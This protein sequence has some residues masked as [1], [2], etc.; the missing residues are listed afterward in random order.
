MINSL[1]KYISAIII[2]NRLP[3]S[4]LLFS[5]F[6]SNDLLSAEYPSII[7]LSD[8][9]EFTGFK[10]DGEGIRD[11]SGFS[12]NTAGDM[13]GDGIDDLVI[14]AIGADFVENADGKTYVIF[15][16][17]DG[18]IQD[19]D[20]SD[21]NGSDGFTITGESEN[22]ETGHSVSTAGDIN[23]DGIGDLIIGAPMAD[24]NYSNSRG[25]SYVVFGRNV[26]KSGS[27]P[28]LVRLD[29]LD[30]S[31]GFELG[32][33]DSFIGSG[34]I[35]NSAGDVN[36]DGIGDLV[37]G[38]RI[39][40]LDSPC[41]L[42]VSSVVFGR[43][44]GT[45]GNFPFFFDLNDLD[46]S[47][48]FH[49]VAESAGDFAGRSVSGAG[50]INNDGFDDLIVG[51]YAGNPN[52]SFSGRSYVIFG[53]NSE[54]NDYFSERFR[55]AELD[56]TNGF[57]MDGEASGD[58]SGRSV[59]SAGDINGDGVDDLII[60]A[61]GAEPN[62]IFSGRTYIVFGRDVSTQGAYPANLQLSNLDGIVG[63]KIDGEN[64][65]DRSGFSVSYAGDINGDNIDDLIIGAYRFSPN[66]VNS[67]RSYVVFGR[68]VSVQGDF[69]S[70]VSL[71]ELNGNNGFIING[72]FSND[73]SG[74]SVRSAGDVNANGIDDIIIG[75]H[76]AD[77]NG[78][79]SGRSYVV[80]GAP[81]IL[82]VTGFE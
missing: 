80:F 19:V 40:L 74:R 61:D 68:N 60:G 48:G 27:F 11:Y 28:S 77:T 82:L 49:I 30:G 18:V 25:S 32:G 76:L 51:A 42:C 20:L 43:D 46:G 58:R 56:G 13:N 53:G 44:V 15:G 22:D 39:A 29:Q 34:F 17:K 1:H 50:D 12:V 59:S 10:I 5:S 57:A 70:I 55:L 64:T 78:D 75:A 31:D 79:S 62:G 69:E 33:V 21:L 4:A 65:Y 71:S 16:Q 63:F 8:L 35:V 73:K 9:N 36:S 6:L 2:S 14:G 67:G 52:G 23:G 24:V 45:T 54:N 66:G 47:N 37:I 72:E 3:I 38:T 41:S 7:E 81:D 26:A